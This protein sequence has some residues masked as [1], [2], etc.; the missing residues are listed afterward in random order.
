METGRFMVWVNG[1]QSSELVNAGKCRPGIAFRD[2]LYESV[3][4]TG[5]QPRRPETGIKDSF[6]EME[7]EFSVWNIPSTKLTTFSDDLLVPEIFRWEE[8]KSRVPFTPCLGQDSSPIM[9]IIS[10]MKLLKV[11][12]PCVQ[13]IQPCL[14][15]VTT[16]K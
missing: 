7:H 9:S 2:H 8:L 13:T 4:F 12:W 11:N 6:E 10:L 1:S 14:W 5:K 16:W 3:P 15:S